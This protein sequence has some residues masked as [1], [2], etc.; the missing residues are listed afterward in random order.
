MVT[1]KA[2]KKREGN[3]EKEQQARNLPP[4]TAIPWTKKI[5]EMGS[6]PAPPPVVAADPPA[7][8]PT[9]PPTELPTE[10]PTLAPMLAAAVVATVA[11]S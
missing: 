11:T 2:K 7:E 10:A 9:E 4:V 1:M 3:T 5:S 8:P 6:P